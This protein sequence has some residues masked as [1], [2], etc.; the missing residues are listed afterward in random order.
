MTVALVRMATGEGSEDYVFGMGGYYDVEH[1]PRLE[2]LS[3]TQLQIT[4]P[5]LS[6]IGLRKTEHAGVQIELR[7]DPD[8]PAGRA[9]W[10]KERGLPPE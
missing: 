10:R 2:W 1:Q 6:L 9:K 7:F 3:T 4:I 5:N 8:D